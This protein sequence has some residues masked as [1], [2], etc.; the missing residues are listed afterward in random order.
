MQLEIINALIQAGVGAIALF[1]V[2]AFIVRFPE[3]AAAIKGIV[4]Q[5]KEA[6]EAGMDRVEGANTVLAESV[7][8]LQ[9]VNKAAITSRERLE[10]RYEEITRELADVKRTFEEQIKQ[11]DEEIARLRAELEQ[12]K[13]DHAKELRAKA[14]ELRQAIAQRDELQRQ[15]DALKLAENPQAD[16]KP[17]SDTK[18]AAA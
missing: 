8:M 2:L 7:K 16:L 9:E 5:I 15:L 11:K 18:A 13:V 4:E 17:A 14:E 6:S 10:S 12:G 1:I 3:N